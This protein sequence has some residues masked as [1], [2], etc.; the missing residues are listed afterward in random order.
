[1]PRLELPYLTAKEHCSPALNAELQVIMDLT[2]CRLL[3]C[4]A[5][6]PVLVYLAIDFWHERL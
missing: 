1:M 2:E 6:K 3:Q 5:P 4:L